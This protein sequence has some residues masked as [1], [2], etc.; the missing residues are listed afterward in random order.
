MAAAASLLAQA[1]RLKMA[2]PQALML[3]VAAL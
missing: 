1:S 3:P 2:E